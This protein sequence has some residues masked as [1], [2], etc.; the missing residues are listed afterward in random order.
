[1]KLYSSVGPNPRVVRM[2]MAERGIDIETVEVD[3]MGGENLGDSY[4]Q[5]NPSAQ[6]PCL[7]LDDGT[8]ISE[9]TVICQYLDEISEGESLVGSTPEESAETRM[10]NRRIDVRILEPMS[11]AFRSAEALALFENRCHVIPQ[12]A[13]DLKATVQENWQWLDGLM[14]GNS[15][16]CGERFTLADIQLFIFAD[17]GNLIGQGIPAECKNLLAWFERVA[18]R[19]SFAASVHPSEAG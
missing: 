10:W 16:I 19:P 6:T 17:F 18:G 9:I 14:A 1:M 7:V 5:L 12:A 11:L 13:D 2:F 8:A 3:I 4:K 15:F